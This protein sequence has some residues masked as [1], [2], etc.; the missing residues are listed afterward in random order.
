VCF[1]YDIL[2]TMRKKLFL[3]GLIILL[4]FCSQAYAADFS[5]H[6]KIDSYN[7]QTK[8]ISITGEIQV[9][10]TADY[11]LTLDYMR[12]IDVNK[13]ESK[14]VYKK[15]YLQAGQADIFTYTLNQ[16]NP[17]EV[18]DIFYKT[19]QGVSTEIKKIVVPK[20]KQT[21]SETPNIKSLSFVSS[22]G[23][24]LFDFY[25]EPE[26]CCLDISSSQVGLSGYIFLHKENHKP[27]ISISLGRSMS[28]LSGQ[29]SINF[30]EK[31]KPGVM[32]EWG[33]MFTKLS[34]NTKYYFVFTNEEENNPDKKTLK[35]LTFSI[36]TKSIEDEKNSKI[37]SDGIRLLPTNPSAKPDNT[38]KDGVFSYSYN[39]NTGDPGSTGEYNLDGS[40]KSIVPKCSYGELDTRCSFKH[41]MI[42]IG[43]IIDFMLILIL[44][45]I[46]I[47]TVIVGIMM[48]KDRSN[49]IK[50]GEHKK[51]V[52]RIVVGVLV[53]LLSW[54]LV[55]TVI[56]VVIG[57]DAKR[58]VL[59]DLASLK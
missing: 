53:I 7:S 54:T 55:A 35:D 1:Y 10:K 50:L 51:I 39:T 29:H 52:S 46:A 31:L 36:T 49:P 20:Q 43:N 45:V 40:E 21:A 47:L 9:N 19:S 56:N 57:D 3:S 12:P 27:E 48:I 38:G 24:K 11:E 14:I 4:G 2:T 30:E 6:E 33:I 44:P 42:L 37:P 23:E 8:T 26:S 13:H 15:R 17:E 16:V 34:S 5:V 41:L 58:Y 59:L 28:N 18:I 22:N 32:T 25:F